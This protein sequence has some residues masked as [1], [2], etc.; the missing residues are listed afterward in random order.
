[1]SRY[2]PE[3]YER[4]WVRQKYVERI[5]ERLDKLLDDRGWPWVRVGKDTDYERALD[6]IQEDLDRLREFPEV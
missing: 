2:G 3:N 4:G 6:L 5:K 1:M